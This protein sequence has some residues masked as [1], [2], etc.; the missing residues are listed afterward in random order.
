MLYSYDTITS[1][2]KQKESLGAIKYVNP[3]NP[4]IYIRV[5]K[6]AEIGKTVQFS[7]RVVIHKA[8]IGDFCIIDGKVTINDDVVIGDRVQI[9]VYAYLWEGVQ[10]KKGSRIQGSVVIYRNTT[11]NERI[12]IFKG[13]QIDENLIV[14][15]NP[16][17][18]KGSK[19]TVY[20]F[21]DTKVRIGCNTL[22]IDEWLKRY[23]EYGET[24]QYTEEEIEEYLSYIKL[25]K[26]Q[27]PPYIR[28]GE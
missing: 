24:N 10:I 11:V 27:G 1:T 20:W 2:W 9:G 16:T 26:A 6:K 5:N 23:K 14:I 8:T 25:L 3:R 21:N 7:S 19:H 12:T 28:K 18:I 22:H 4:E 15:K 17:F 13:M